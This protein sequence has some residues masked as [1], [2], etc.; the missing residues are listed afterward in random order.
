LHDLALYSIGN[1]VWRTGY[2]EF[3]SV[4]D[5]AGSAD[6]REL[7]EAL[8]SYPDSL[9]DTRSG[10]RIIGRNLLVDVLQPAAEATRIDD[11]ARSHRGRVNR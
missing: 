8:D 1:D 3:A 11:P 5:P 10:G 4:R 2:D 6:R 7:R 9:D